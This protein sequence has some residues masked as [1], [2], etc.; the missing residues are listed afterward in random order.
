M[1]D[2]RPVHSDDAPAAIGPYSQAVVT[3]DLVFTS[4]QI[5]LDPSTARL[6]DGGLGPQVEQ[7]M[8]NLAAVLAAAGTSL[9]RAVKVTIY[10]TDLG[11]FGELN[12]IYGRV[13][14]A[15]RPARATVEVSRLPMDALVEMDCVAR[16]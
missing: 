1:S 4:G 14:G 9:E 5:G 12:E 6:V 15:A 8:K 11:G 2:P 3:G 10:V 7:V 13:L 16:I